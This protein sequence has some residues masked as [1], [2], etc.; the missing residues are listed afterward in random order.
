M[1]SGEHNGKVSYKHVPETILKLALPLAAVD[2][3]EEVER[4]KKKQKLE[5]GEDGKEKSEKVLPNIP[6]QA[7][8]D[9][10]NLGDKVDI[11]NAVATKS[12]KFSK[13]SKYIWVNLQRVVVNA[14][15]QQEKLDHT[16]FVPDVLDLSS[17]KGTGKL[18][19]EIELP[20]DESGA[21]EA[22]SP[23]PDANIVSQVAALGFSENAGKRAARSSGR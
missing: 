4:S 5:E 18:D 12:T 17:M 14:Q 13:F 9:Q 2:N 15:W 7:L 19:S 10:F 21:A 16:V 11:R 6:F 3:M 23:V 22:A 20:N 1:V 8:L